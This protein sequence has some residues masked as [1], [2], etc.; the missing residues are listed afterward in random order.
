MLWLYRALWWLGLPAVL[1]Y[2]WRRARGDADYWRWR[3]ERFGRYPAFAP[4][5]VWIHAV[6]LGEM[7]SAAPIVRALLA[8]GERVVTTHFTPAGRRAA[9]G[10]FAPEIAAGQVLP[11]WVPFEL[12][13]AWRRFIA[14]FRP[15]YGLVMEIEVWPGMILN[16]RRAGLA[17][18][19]CNAQY[20][21]R[22][23]ARDTTRLTV[24][25]ELMRF[26]AGAMVK[27]EVQRARFASVGVHPIAVTGETRFDQPIPPEQ[28][29][30]ARPVRVAL[31]GARPVVTLSSVVE[32]E[33]ALYLGAIRESLAAHEAAGLAPPLFVYVPRAPERFDEVG[34]MIAGAGLRLAA[35]SAVL[36]PDLALVRDPGEIDVLL[37]DSLGEMYFYIALADRVLIGGGFTAR[38]AH[39]VIEPLAVGRPVMVGPEIRT[40]EYPAVE[41]I[42]AGVC[43]HLRS[44]EDLRASLAPGGAAPVEAGAI[45]AFLAAHSGAADR[46]L[47]AIPALLAAQPTSR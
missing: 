36:G 2:L 29:A 4:G 45:D 6:S 33:D 25:A 43:Q 17:L 13:F 30:A 37:G 42:A 20:P 10:L 19:M 40:I 21:A 12:G 35:R 47:A 44:P 39:N 8:R 16:S 9:H 41:A 18:F 5:A 32:G 26:Y 46:T 34:A 11:V 22:S 24:R 23:Y 3:A 31:A 14:H 15:A 28:L 1:L 27:S 7:R 38:G